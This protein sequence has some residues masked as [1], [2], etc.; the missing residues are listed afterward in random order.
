MT[1]AR[2]IRTVLLLTFGFAL[3]GVAAPAAAQPRPAGAQAAVSLLDAIDQGLVRAEFTGNGSASGAAM[4]LR[5]TRTSQ[6]DLTLAVPV[7]VLLLNGDAEE[8]DMVVRQ[9]L[10]ESSGGSGY[11]PL[12]LI[13]LRD[14]D[15]HVFIL[16]A[17]CL[18]AHLDNP[19]RGSG[20]T[21]AGL[22][23]EGVVAVLVAVDRVPD[24][25]EEITAIQAAVWAITD[26][27]SRDELDEIGYGLEDDEAQLVAEI[28]SAAGFDATTFR[29]FG[30]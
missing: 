6:S 20:F 7:G 16:E 19:S 29:L 13:E 1:R 15:E 3:A 24:A 5:I 25:D 23:G 18:E 28:L 11:R 8:Q 27:I 14:G 2:I 26:N 22:V 10:G 9:L 12:T 21:L 4:L 17:Y 30:G